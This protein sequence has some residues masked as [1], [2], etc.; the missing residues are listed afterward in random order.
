MALA[1]QEITYYQP[2]ECQVR[3]AWEGRP[4][5]PWSLGVAQLTATCWLS[6]SESPSLDLSGGAQTGWRIEKNLGL[7]KVTEHTQV[8]RWLEC[9]QGREM[10]GVGAE[11]QKPWTQSTGRCALRSMAEMGFRVQLDHQQTAGAWRNPPDS[12][13]RFPHL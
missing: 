3:G 4:L 6:C 2:P 7:Q 1:K 9:D 5:H 11:E 12:E 8:L 10:T 13:S